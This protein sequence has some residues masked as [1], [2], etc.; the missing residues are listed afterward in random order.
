[1]RDAASS[2]VLHDGIVRARR[3]E[4]GIAVHPHRPPLDRI[5]LVLA[6]SLQ[7]AGG[8]IR[9]AEES[10]RERCPPGGRD[11]RDSERAHGVVSGEVRSDG[12]D[13]Q[14][15]ARRQ[16]SVAP[17]AIG[18]A[19]TGGCRPERRLEV[20]AQDGGRPF[21]LEESPHQGGGCCMGDRLVAPIDRI[22]GRQAVRQNYRN[23]IR[24]R[25]GE[26][27]HA[28]CQHRLLH[29]PGDPHLTVG[30]VRANIRLGGDR[31]GS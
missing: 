20:V 19:E 25:R 26:G 21:R 31:A 14:T 27:G 17:Q 30:V 5:S 2:V 1:M 6:G 11:V 13:E 15:F 23:A 18:D 29:V 4:V 24:T 8:R 16:D 28:V 3:C 10:V 9:Q 7:V 12:V 22:G